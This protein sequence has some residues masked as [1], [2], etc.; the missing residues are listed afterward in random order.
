MI[1]A[2]LVGM[3][4]LTYWKL[5]S[6]NWLY[7][8]YQ[9]EGFEFTKSQIGNGLFSYKKGWF[10]YT[11]LALLGFIGCVIVYRTVKLRFYLI[12]FLMYFSLSIYVLFSWRMWY[13]GGSFGSRVLIESLALLAFPIAAFSDFI[14]SQKQILLKWTF[15]MVF[16]FGISLNLFQSWQYHNSI[17]H[18]DSMNKAYY[19]RIFGKTKSSEED[20]MLIKQ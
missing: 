13:Y 19:W 18:W 7:Y 2:F 9:D 14:F 15:T 20:R 4:Q 10:V 8:S 6:G 5:S 11:P 3:I 17:I 16:I 12:P 1:T